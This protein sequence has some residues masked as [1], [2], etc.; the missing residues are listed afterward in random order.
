MLFLIETNELTRECHRQGHEQEKDSYYPGEFARKFISAEEEDLH[1]VNEDNG[2]HEVRTPP[3]HSADEPT[4]TYVVIQT[5]QT[6]PGPA[7]RRNI[8]ECEHDSGDELQKEH[9]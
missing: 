4:Q 6:V 9:D 5:L 2:H 7:G 8:N 1:H 3:V